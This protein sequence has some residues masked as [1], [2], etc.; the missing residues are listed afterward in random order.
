MASFTSFEVYWATSQPC[1]AAHDSAM[2][3]AW[4]TPMAVFALV[5][6]NTRSTTTTAGLY[7][8]SSSRR[9][10]ASS[11]RRRST[12]AARSVSIVPA[13]LAENRPAVSRANS[14][15][16]QRVSPGSIP[17]TNMCSTVVDSPG[18]TRDLPVVGREHGL[19]DVEVGM[20]RLDVIVVV[21]RV[22]EPQHSLRACVV[23]DLD[24]RGR[25]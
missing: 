9:A 20:D 25:H 22:H 12:V 21:D 4:A 23:G 19:R 13:A 6:K 15:Y 10:W 5:W 7:W 2:P 18:A 3:L 11:Q 16:P 8:T 24:G 14:P 17:R 1:A